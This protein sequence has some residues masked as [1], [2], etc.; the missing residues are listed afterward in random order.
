[1]KNGFQITSFSILLLIATTSLPAQTFV[2]NGS[3]SNLG[4][5]CYQLT[6]NTGG[7]AGSIFS[8]T[9]IDLTQP[10]AIDVRMYFGDKD[11]NGADGI[12]F[13]FATSNTALGV[14]GGGLGYQN[15]TPSI[16][17]EYDDY[18]NGWGDPAADH[19]A[20]ISNGNL[21]HNAPTNLVGPIVLANI[22][23]DEEHC[24]SM[25]WDPVTF[26]LAATLDGDAIFYTG[27]IVNSI[28]AGNP[29]VY[30][31]FSSGTGSLSNFHRVCF[32]PPMVDPM[33]DV[34]VCEG[35]SVDLQADENGIAW[36]W[37]PD[38]TLSPWNV[39][40]PTATPD[41]TTTYYVDIDYACDGFGRDTVVVTVIPEPNATAAN[42]GPVCIGESVSLIASGGTMY[43]WSGPMGYS[44]S[45]QNP[46]INSMTPGKAGTYTVTVTDAAG[47]TS[48]A[49]TDVGVFDIPSVSIDPFTN[50]LCEDGEPVQL[51]GDPGGGDWGGTINPNGVFDPQLTGEGSYPISYTITDGNGCTNSDEII[52]EVVPNIPAEILPEGP[53]CVTDP[54]ITLIANPPGGTWGESADSDGQIYPGTLG[55]GS[56]LVT[57]ELTGPDECYNTE[58]YIEIQAAPVASINPVLPLCLNSPPVNL[59]ATPPGGAWSGDAGPNGS[60]DPAALGSGIHQAIYVY[61]ISGGCADTATLDFVVLQDAP[62]IQNFLVTCDSVGEFYTISFTISGGD[63]ATYAVQSVINGTLTSGN[64]YI[65]SSDPIPTG[66]AYSFVVDDIHHCDPVNIAGS[67]SCNCPTNAGFMDQSPILACEDE[68]VSIPLPTGVNLDPNDTLVYVLHTGNPDSIL[69]TGAPNL[70]SFAPPLQA[71]VTYFISAIAGNVSGDSVDLSDPCLS[72]TNGPSVTWYPNPSGNLLAPSMIC[73]GDSAM[74]TFILNG[75]GPFNVGYSDGATIFSL[76][77]ISSGYTLQVQPSD[78]IQ[79]SLLLIVDI[80]SSGCDI[81]PNT[82]VAINVT[83]VIQVQQSASICD[84]DSLW[85]GGSYQY[86]AGIY[87][88]TLSAA[89]GCD[90]IV[91]TSLVIR[92]LD[93]TYVSSTTC[94][95]AQA[96]VF[97][98]TISNVLG[99][100]ST[101]IHTVTFVLADTTLLQSFTCDPAQTGTF[102]DMYISQDGCDS[103]VITDI[104]LLA[105]D[106]TH[107][108]G[109]TCDPSGVGIF[110]QNLTNVSGC[111]SI[112]IETISLLPSDVVQLSGVSCNPA[113]TGFF[114][115]M[116]QN[117]YG[118]D[119]LVTE[120][121]SLAPSYAIQQ[122]STTCDPA[123]AGTFNTHLTTV[124]GCDSLITSIV[125]LLPSDTILTFNVTCEP[126]DTGVLIQPYINVFGC[127]SLI[128]IITSL[129]PEDS[130]V[131]EQI[132]KDVFVPNVFSPNNDGINDYF[133][134]FAKPD[135]VA[136]IQFLRIYD[137]W[138]G[139]V[140]ERLDFPPNDYAYAWDGSE[141]NKAVNP[142]VFVWNIRI[143]FVDGTEEVLFGDVTLVR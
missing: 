141:K 116:L 55:V 123:A 79:Y 77:S 84:G 81:S 139:L 92:P 110:T 106:T 138:G 43:Q 82:S 134:V 69:V 115:M 51:F 86:D 61:S 57:Y 125:S 12:V 10:F 99:C 1:M 87:T 135:V 133:L 122:T 34:T 32:G 37:D 15:I 26:T 4:G 129:A 68:T 103:I 111:D 29:V 8:T 36:S 132:R 128:Y 119:S 114:Q 63:P 40:D 27:D 25:L 35:E 95:M 76:D 64:P 21:D 100:D 72:V 41:V 66:N 80:S 60:V 42:T 96:G 101:V 23:D 117:V 131:V 5:G 107:L 46:V 65:F 104:L 127:D 71:G 30:Y 16:A 113:D 52:I 56:H 6:P 44:S 48:T 73:N 3:A 142:G 126:L 91:E 118:C 74:L 9:P 45:Q 130:C 53:F 75:T 7:Q 20:V 120:S 89:A 98:N 102:T 38:P 136:S 62:Q 58:I 59:T 143:R 78:T 49:E 2:T 54:V 90:S 88:D 39:S 22:E 70:F 14:G 47:C 97:Q 13:I 31:G 112:V 19:M 85:V 33:P 17:I 94:D 140:T 93:T 121:I 24:F 109:G 105:S 83:N 108:T 11:A 28:F 67:Y 124:Q 18:Q 137:R 50:P